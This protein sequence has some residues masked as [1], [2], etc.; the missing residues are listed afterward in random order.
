VP[1]LPWGWQSG[2]VRVYCSLDPQHLTS[3]HPCWEA[4]PHQGSRHALQRQ[5]AA[6]QGFFAGLHGPWVAPSRSSQRVYVCNRCT[7]EVS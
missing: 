6:R 3:N 7:A 2:L 1:R 5:M 4:G